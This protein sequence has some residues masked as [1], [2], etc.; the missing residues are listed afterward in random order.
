VEEEAQKKPVYKGL[1]RAK[2]LR[3][4]K[5]LAEIACSDDYI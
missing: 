3:Y 4:C 1:S 5:L 2:A